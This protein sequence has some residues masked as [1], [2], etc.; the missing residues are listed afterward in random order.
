MLLDNSEGLLKVEAELR[1]GVIHH[2]A[3][4]CKAWVQSVI[5]EKQSA[6]KVIES[7]SIE[8]VKKRYGRKKG[9]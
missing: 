8:E 2:Q 7:E 5:E 3:H 6:G 1:K 4:P 9:L